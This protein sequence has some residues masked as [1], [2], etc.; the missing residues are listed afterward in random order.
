MRRSPLALVILAA[1]VL[2]STGCQSASGPTTVALAPSQYAQAFE[3]YLRAHEVPPRGPE[4][5]SVPA[6]AS[7]REGNGRSPI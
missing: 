4:P 6:A 7:L 5:S 2:A 1:L 3:H